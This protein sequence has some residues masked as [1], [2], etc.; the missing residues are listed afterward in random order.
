[1]EIYKHTI[2]LYLLGILTIK[3]IVMYSYFVY[4]QECIN[5]SSIFINKL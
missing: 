2:M 3:N 1:M 5:L 4:H